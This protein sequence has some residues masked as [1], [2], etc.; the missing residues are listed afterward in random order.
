MSTTNDRRPNRIAII[1]GG[2][3][4]L[5]AAHR[6]HELAPDAEVSLYEA[7]DRLGGVIHT[8]HRDGYLIEQ[9]ADSF[10][11]NVP[12]AIDLCRRIG[13]E[14]ELIPTDERFRRAL[15]VRRG[16]LYPVPEGFMLMQ[17]GKLWPVLTTPLLSW[18]GK[19]RLACEYFVRRRHKT[20]AATVLA[21]SDD[22]TLASF[23][24][25][26]LGREAFENLVQPLVGGIYTADPEQLS[27]A[28]T[29]P[30]FLE[31]EREY[32]SLM[33]AAW[34]QAKERPRM[35]QR[36]KEESGAR[37]GMF[38]APRH[39]LTSLIEA[40]AARLPAAG[41]QLSVPVKQLARQTEGGWRLIFDLPKGDAHV[42]AVVLATPAPVAARLLEPIDR[43][44]AGEIAGIP[45]A[46]ATI[47]CVAYDR[48]QI[49]HALDG[50]GFVVPAIE[51]RRILA[52]SFSSVKFA[53][54]APEGK[55]LIRV[56]VGGALQPQLG[57]F[58]DHE[59]RRIVT[60]ELAELLAVRGEPELFTVTRWSGAMPQYHIGH[61]ERVA[62]IETRL[63]QLPGLQLA[64][65]AYH[66]VG[67]PHC[68]HSGERAA[69]AIWKWR[70]ST[71]V[72]H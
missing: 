36:T 9:S 24:R 29:L 44:L 30:R 42:D 33:R 28:A 14:T 51:N 26:R 35:K 63:A 18:R 7:G 15:V 37:Y 47:A 64:G 59:L 62:R 52:A 53:G 54:R 27:V 72:K 65:N 23:A 38:V 68:I 11:T 56:F 4:G 67:I 3:A 48:S 8:I 22:E 60:E 41:I 70:S 43:V 69:E 34:Q 57:D 46:G 32:G 66:G 17:P 31:M 19:L 16:K 49:G 58:P 45:H 6:V 40:I 12:W 13:F 2:I 61:L 50:F 71:A 39:G 21:A 20:S 5:S 55:V 1:G 25:R 10:I